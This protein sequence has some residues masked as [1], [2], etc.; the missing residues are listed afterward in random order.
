[1]V[2]E[3]RE[4]EMTGIVVVDGVDDE[5]LGKEGGKAG[6]LAQCDAST[7]WCVGYMVT[8]RVWLG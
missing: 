2:G 5:G 8:C 6:R 4:R 3:G 1:M 7:R